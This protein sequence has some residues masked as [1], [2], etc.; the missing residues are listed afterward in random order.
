M[1]SSKSS[2]GP[3]AALLTV[4]GSRAAPTLRQAA[5]QLDLAVSDLDAEF[6]VI[7][8]DPEKQLYAVRTTASGAVAHPNAFSDPK[9]ETFGPR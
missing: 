6:G 2:Q 8:I 1:N 5:L 9:I 4:K 3:D 7:L